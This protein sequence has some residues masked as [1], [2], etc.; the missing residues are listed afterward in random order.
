M[1]SLQRILTSLLF[2]LIK[3]RGPNP[4]LITTIKSAIHPTKKT[5][6]CNYVKIVPQKP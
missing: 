3:I 4:E 2:K 6:N 1:A 5:I